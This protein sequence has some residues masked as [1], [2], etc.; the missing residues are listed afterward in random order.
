M[1]FAERLG[2]KLDDGLPENWPQE[3]IEVYIGEQVSWS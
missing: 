3:K 2:L 1:I